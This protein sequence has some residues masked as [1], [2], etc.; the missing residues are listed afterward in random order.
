M[1]RLLGTYPGY[2]QVPDVNMYIEA[3]GSQALFKTAFDYALEK[4]RY[5]VVSMLPEITLNAIQ[6]ISTQPMIYGSKGDEH[7]NIIEVIDLLKQG[8]TKMNEIITSKY[9][10]D[11]FPQAIA[12]AASGKDIKVIINFENK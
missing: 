4:T 2:F 1:I 6:F 10:I 8:K 7:E 11:E 5:C 12:A 3:S 9:T